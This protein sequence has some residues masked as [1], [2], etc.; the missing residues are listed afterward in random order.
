MTLPL[1]LVIPL[2]LLTFLGGIGLASLFLTN[3]FQRLLLH[4]SETASVQEKSLQALVSRTEGERDLALEQYRQLREQQE[5]H[6]D[7]LDSLIPIREQLAQVSHKVQ[8]L[9]RNQTQQSVQLLTKLQEESRLH[10]ELRQ[11]TAALNSAL[12][13]TSSRGS[14][15]ELQLKRIVE[16]SGMLEHVDFS[17][18]K[19]IKD[20]AKRPDMIV[21]LP[22]GGEIIIDAKAPL[23]LENE[24]K[25]AAALRNLITG[26]A[27]RNYPAEHPNSPQL[28]VLFL[29]SEAMLSQAL[30][31]DEALLDYALD[32]KIA[33]C[34]PS[35]LFA[36]LRAVASVW[37]GAS[38]SDEAKEI[39]ALGQSMVKRLDIFIKHL[40]KL[41]SNLRSATRSYNDAITSLENRLLPAVR[42][43]DS[44]DLNTKELGQDLTKIIEQADT[45]YESEG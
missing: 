27:K 16:L 28:T 41:G 12:T 39:V 5:A 17:T 1:A 31:S 3:R 33:L 24:T 30:N 18:Q 35:S 8:D 45:R 6:G 23:N 34:S 21:H 4:E 22:G 9:D 13:A 2:C 44:L 25:Q 36:L 15:G 11:T 10:A 19:I 40:G 32:R 42:Q 38:A 20:T 43:F 7:V 37:Q 26:L 29:P 14:W